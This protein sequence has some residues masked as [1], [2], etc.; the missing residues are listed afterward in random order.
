M[1]GLLEVAGALQEQQ[2]A[3]VPG[4]LAGLQHRPDARAD[5]V[6]DLRPHLAG[7]AAQRPR[8]L[9]PQR[10]VRVG[11]VVEERQLGTPR[12]PHREARGQQDLHHLPQRRR[13]VLRTPHR[14]RGPVPGRHHL[15]HT[16]AAG[17]DR[18]GRPVSLSGHDVPPSASSDPN[19]RPTQPRSFE[20]GPYGAQLRA[21]GLRARTAGDRRLRVSETELT[22]KHR[23]IQPIV[24]RGWES[25]ARLSVLGSFSH[26]NQAG[27]SPPRRTSRPHDP[28]TR[29]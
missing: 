8:V 4:G 19:R 13:P 21:A 27:P 10:V 3:L 11:V 28:R 20:V 23:A 25:L 2:Q 1:V 5:V 24:S 29:G 9:G 22:S 17:E 7:R 14:G 26:W 15:A 18:V 12:H 6:P 16:T